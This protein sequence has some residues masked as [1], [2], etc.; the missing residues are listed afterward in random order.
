MAVG[1]IISMPNKNS[2]F[3]RLLGADGRQYTVPK[4]KLPEDSSVDKEFAY[5]VELWSNNS[6]LIT[7]LEEED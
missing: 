6:G 7:N 5:K 4:D 2:S 3:G 1:R